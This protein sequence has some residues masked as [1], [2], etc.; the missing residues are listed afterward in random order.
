MKLNFVP[1]LFLEVAELNRFKDSLD[2]YGFRKHI[3]QNTESYGLIKNETVDPNFLNG[4]VQIDLDDEFGNKTI[5]INELFGIDSFGNFIYH[6]IKRSIIIPNDNNWYWVR[7]TYQESV[8]EK[9]TFSISSNGNLVGSGSELLSILRGQPNFPSRIKF[10]NS[11]QNTL[12]YDILEVIDNQNAIVSHPALTNLGSSEFIPETGLTIGVVGTFTPGVVVPTN[13][14][15]PFRYDSTLIEILQESTLN[16][17]PPYIVNSNFYIARC[18]IISGVLVIQDKRTEF[19]ESKGSKRSLNIERNTNP[20]IGVENIKWNHVNTPADRNIVEIGWGMRTQNWSVDTSNNILTLFGSSKGG[21]FKSVEDFT[22]GDFNGWR[23]YSQNGKYS[24]VLSSVKQGSS[25][26]LSLDTLDIDNFSIDGG[27]T[28][29]SGTDWVLVTPDCEEVEI[30]CIPESS[31]GQPFMTKVFCFPV[32]TLL[33]KLELVVYKNPSCRYEISYRYKSFKEYIDYSLIP[34][35]EVGYYDETSFLISTGELKPLEDR[36]EKPYEDGLVE[37]LLAPH[38]YLN[39]TNRVDRGDIYGVRTFTEL[40]D[41]TYI[42]TVKESELYNH[43]VGS[44]TLPNNIKFILSKE[45]ARDLNKFIFHLQADSINLSGF[46]ITIEQYTT[47]PTT[48]VLKT[49]TQSDIY[50]MLN[51]E[52][53]VKLT[54]VYDQ[55]NQTWIFTQNYDTGR[56]NEI[57]TMDGVFSDLFETSGWG[58]VKGLF[59]YHLCNG[60]DGTPN[61]S[62]RFIV[63]Y[64]PEDSDYDETGNTGPNPPII[65]PTLGYE[66][67]DGGKQIRIASLGI[68]EHTHAYDR[69]PEATQ[70]VQ[71]SGSAE[72]QDAITQTG[73]EEVKT[74]GQ[75]GNEASEIDTEIQFAP[76]P[77]ENRPPYYT[78]FYVKKMF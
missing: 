34:N 6:P 63:G 44:I 70:S 41:P 33:A 72:V 75:F 73:Y 26:N 45:N 29:N 1:N 15:Y 43:I 20:L 51:Q 11:T 61:L 30:R 28:T 53:G 42:L 17:K 65:G 25:I 66:L 48:E 38:S 2:T 77:I 35:D 56:P 31:D 9:G 8:Q 3:L 21:K 19:W 5:K 64:D 40:T 59:G 54:F 58:K 24:K 23:L 55:D 13:D 67:V 71:G 69:V 47:E 37:L 68:P 36:N 52:G 62:G 12:E 46:S 7:V 10:L 4:K 74:K 18:K 60:E 14:K 32:N 50:T 16:T 57:I 78:L 76:S 39:F 27:S 22:D 49:I